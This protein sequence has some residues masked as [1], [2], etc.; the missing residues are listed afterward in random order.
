M[1]PDLRIPTTPS[2][3]VARGRADIVQTVA[4]QTPQAGSTGP[5]VGGP[6]INPPAAPQNPLV[7]LQELSRQAIENYS[8]VDSYIARLQRREQVNGR[9]KPL[10]IIL[11]KFR[12]QPWSVYFKWLGSE[13]QGR[14]VTFVKGAHEGKIHTLLA[15]GDVPLLP[16]GRRMAL[17]PDSPLV[18]GSSRHTILE[19]GVGRL[20]ESF[21]RHVAAQAGG[22]PALLAYLG[23]IRRP[24]MPNGGEG[25][26]QTIPVGSDPLLPRGGKRLWVFDP[27]TKFPVLILTQNETGHEVEYYY[28]DRFEFPVRLD[29]DDFNPERL[30]PRKP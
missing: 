18:R 17:L 19:A 26:A 30:W 10:E 11:F 21:G 6:D 22:G 25:V 1:A 27:V 4:V 23:V 7:R 9:D 13:A 28:Y 14:E 29:D 2:S 15:G 5:Q 8:Q 12:K 24:E 16:A 20:V 3:T